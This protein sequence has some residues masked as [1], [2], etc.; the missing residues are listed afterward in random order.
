MG[1]DAMWGQAGKRLGVTLSCQLVL[2]ANVRVTHRKEKRQ[3]E[4]GVRGSAIVLR[5]GWISCTRRP[6]RVS[7]RAIFTPPDS[8][9]AACGGVGSGPKLRLRRWRLL[10]TGQKERA[11]SPEGGQRAAAGVGESF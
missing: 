10:E 2:G 7:G 4:C 3:E 6:L 1:G 9:S 5:Q 8:G 11:V